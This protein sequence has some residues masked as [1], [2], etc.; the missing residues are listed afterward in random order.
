[1]R[2]VEK[3]KARQAAQIE[4]KMNPERA[5]PKQSCT[6]LEIAEQ[7]VRDALATMEAA[8]RA[9]PLA[10]RAATEKHKTAQLAFSAAKKRL[11]AAR[12]QAKAVSV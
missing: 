9:I 8:V 1:M 12:R 7:D 5:Q 6:P 11:R 4:P 2:A 10:T 3:L